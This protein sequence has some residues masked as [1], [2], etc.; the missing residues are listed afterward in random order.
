MH[1]DFGK[2]L[3]KTWLTWWLQST[4]KEMKKLELSSISDN[5]PR[6]ISFTSMKEVLKAPVE[7]FEDGSSQNA[8]FMMK[9][10]L[11]SK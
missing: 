3:T 8:I 2:R 5:I 9:G 11:K 6:K 7:R 10:F 4:K 1:H